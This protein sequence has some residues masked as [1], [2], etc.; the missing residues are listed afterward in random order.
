MLK[1]IGTLG[2]VVLLTACQTT[3]DGGSNTHQLS[4]NQTPQ[5]IMKDVRP[6]STQARHDKWN[7]DM[8]TSPWVYNLT[9]I[10]PARSGELSQRFELRNGD[11]TTNQ[12]PGDSHP[13][14]WGCHNQRERAEIWGKIWTPGRDQWIGLSVMVGD[15]WKKTQK[16]HCT[17]VFQIKQMEDNVYQ[18]NKP[19]T[20]SGDFSGGHYI[21]GH[22]VMHGQICGDKFGVAIKRTGFKDNKYNGWEKTQ[23]ISFGKIAEIQKGWNDIQLRWDTRD[24]RNGNSKLELYFNGKKKAE[25]KNITSNFFPDTYIF[26]YGMYRSYMDQWG[27]TTGTQVMYYD[28]IRYGNSLNAVNPQN[29]TAMD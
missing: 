4:P 3:V 10:V 25:L 15:D 5:I 28:E 7:Q 29:K 23:N 22:A 26:K 21:G 13:N 2:S 27:V 17:S 24:Y 11:C 6:K 8:P 20:K 18:G 16:N 14:D 12:P 19:G 9:N 1:T